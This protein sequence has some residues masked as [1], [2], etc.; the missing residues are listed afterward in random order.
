MFLAQIRHSKPAVYSVLTSAVYLSLW[1]CNVPFPG[2]SGIKT[3]SGVRLE[4]SLWGHFLENC[5]NSCTK[6][7]LNLCVFARTF[8][9]EGAIHVCGHHARDTCMLFNLRFF[10]LHDVCM[11]GTLDARACCRHTVKKSRVSKRWRE[12]STNKIS[13]ESDTMLQ[14]AG[15]IPVAHERWHILAVFACSLCVFCF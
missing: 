7:K 12:K 10:L 15:G 3:S 8:S 6:P 9:G 1:C 2:R 13:G 14:I 4:V 11:L 5:I